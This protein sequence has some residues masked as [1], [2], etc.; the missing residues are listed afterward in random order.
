MS[1][2]FDGIELVA[3]CTGNLIAGLIVG[4]YACAPTPVQTVQHQRLQQAKD[5]A[6]A[7]ARADV[8]E[9]LFTLRPATFEGSG[10]VAALGLASW[11]TYCDGTAAGHAVVNAL[12]RSEP[13]H[14]PT[15][16]MH[17]VNFGR[18]VSIQ[19]GAAEAE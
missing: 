18:G 3:A 2:R 7:L 4:A 10:R 14:M 1:V 17:L 5:Q 9:V 13:G 19:A 15:L 8:N 6:C 16:R 11:V 12:W